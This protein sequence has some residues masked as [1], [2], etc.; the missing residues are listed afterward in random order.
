MNHR[1]L[2]AVSFLGLASLGALVAPSMAAAQCQPDDIFCAE[3]RIGPGGPPPPPPPIVV[4]PPPPP[5]VV[6]PP[7]PVVI[8]QPARPQPPPQP[9]VIV[10][11]R[12]PPPPQ[13]VA[14][15]VERRRTTRYE[16]V[17]ESQLGIHLNL[18]GMVL[19]EDSGMGGVQAGFRLRP[20]PHIGLDLSIGAF[21]GQSFQYEGN[22][23]DRWEVPILADV[24]FFLNPQHRVQFYFLVGVGTSFAEQQFARSSREFVYLGG[25]AGIGLEFRIGRHFA[26]NLDLR[27]FVRQQVGEGRPEF[28]RV[29][30]EGTIQS[31]NTSGGMYGTAGMTFYFGG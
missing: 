11:Q 30:D 10:V 19:G 4:Q 28:E 2:T 12:Q 24:L 5:V 18:A 15:Q 16:L 1:I 20:I 6:Q 13:V 26:I 14:V 9:R 17:P 21:G 3:L 31:T 25:E 27:G 7:P 22:G 23:G 8:V 29:T